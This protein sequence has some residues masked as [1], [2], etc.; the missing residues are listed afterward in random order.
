[1][2]DPSDSAFRERL[3]VVLETASAR[4]G[5]R[6]SLAQADAVLRFFREDSDTQMSVVGQW[7]RLR[8]ENDRLRRN[9]LQ[10]E[11]PIGPLWRECGEPLDD[12]SGRVC[13]RVC[14][15]GRDYHGGGHWYADPDLDGGYVRHSTAHWLVTGKSA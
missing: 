10:Y 3:A 6:H 7:V 8:G 13:R 9:L 5:E 2:A 15:P 11:A 1:M 4:P 14:A 12:D